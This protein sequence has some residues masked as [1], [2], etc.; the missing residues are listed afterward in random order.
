[1]AAMTRSGDQPVDYFFQFHQVKRLMKKNIAAQMLSLVDHVLVHIAGIH[2]GFD[3][4]I[5]LFGDFKHKKARHV[6][7]LEVYHDEMRQLYPD[8]LNRLFARVRALHFKAFVLEKISY[9]L[10][11]PLLVIDNEQP[12]QHTI[13]GRPSLSAPRT[14][15]ESTKRQ[16]LRPFSI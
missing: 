10:D 2:D 6:G 5:E 13:T 14:P 12:F 16:F 3:A 4:R 8:R 9:L 1:M 11:N 15:G 7:K